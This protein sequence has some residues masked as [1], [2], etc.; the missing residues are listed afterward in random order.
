MLRLYTVYS[1]FTQP[2][3]EW[4]GLYEKYTKTLNHER[5]SGF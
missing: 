4:K 5:T 3:R 2:D 1:F